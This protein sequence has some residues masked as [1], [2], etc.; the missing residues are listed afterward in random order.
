MAAP[1][2]KV[3]DALE[4][5]RL[6][7]N[8]LAPNR[9]KASDGSIGDAA[10]A[11]R[12]SDHNPWWSFAGQPYVTARDFTH[13]PAGGL[14]CAWLARIIQLRQD[15]RVKYVI[16]RRS[17]MSGDGGPSPWVWRKYSGANPHEKHLHLSVVADAR[18]LSAIP[19]Q[20]EEPTGAHPVQKPT[21]VPEEDEVTP[22]LERM[23][24]EIH[25]ETTTTLPNRRGDQGRELPGGGA[26]TLFGY[27]MN[28]DGA[29]FRASWTLA[30]I[31]E[32]QDELMA[33]LTG[34]AERLAQLPA[35]QAQA[36][37][38]DQLAAALLRQMAPR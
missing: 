37:T 23:I 26:D 9:S 32:R 38:P 35:A 8:A 15:P 28:V 18:A 2:W 22:E 31:A 13:D 27:A 6:Q 30:D 36:I 7:L 29:A 5:L 24:R 33:A 10:H 12:S 25:R 3:A 11:S 1:A 17:I 34:L 19:W 16:F 14:D 20:L 4:R 21:P